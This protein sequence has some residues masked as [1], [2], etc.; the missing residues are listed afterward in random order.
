MEKTLI[1]LRSRTRQRAYKTWLLFNI[2]LDFLANA[3]IHE[4]GIERT[5]RRRNKKSGR[6]GKP[7]RIKKQTIR[8]NKK[9]WQS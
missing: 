6:Y 4:K 2:L 7:S 3:I 1:T 9:C 8:T 5:E